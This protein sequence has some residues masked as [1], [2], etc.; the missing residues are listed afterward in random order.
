MK[1]K[2]V[3][4]NNKL[5]DAGFILRACDGY[6]QKYILLSN[7][8]EICGNTSVG[9]FGRRL[10]GGWDIDKAYNL[11]KETRYK[12]IK[13]Q[14][15]EKARKGGINCQKQN[16]HIREIAK[17]NC[18]KAVDSGM[19]G[20]VV[21]HKPWNTGLTKENDLRVM[22]ISKRQLGEGNPMFG[23]VPTQKERQAASAKMKENIKSGKFTPNIRNSQTHWQVKYKGKK[24]RSSWEAA[25]FAL[26]TSYEYETVRISYW[27]NAE[28]KIYIVDFYDPVT[29]TL[30]EIK[31]TAHTYDEK[32]KAKKL[33]AEKWAA[34]NN[35]KYLVVTQEYLK[36]N[37]EFLLSSD[38][39][40]DVKDKIRN[41]K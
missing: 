13:E 15:S 18:R 14:K 23:Y 17:E 1:G 39:P 34:E 19:A 22:K 36:E 5:S 3:D 33:W 32:F 29:K 35:G 20:Y 7:G 25:W 4:W 24:F 6:T 10:S 16:P 41:I 37:M 11:N 30:V 12:Y 21:G 40:D 26:N 27:L 38:L 9:R 28:E 8:I 2:K 31:P